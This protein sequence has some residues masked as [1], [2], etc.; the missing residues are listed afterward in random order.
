MRRW[1]SIAIISLVLMATP[2]WAQSYRLVWS[3]EFNGTVLDATK[4]EQQTGTGCPSLCGWGNNELEYYRPENTSVAGGLLTITAKAEVFGGANYTSS[5]IR[6]RLK[7]DW[8]YGRIEIRAKLPAGRGLWPAFWMLPTDNAY[9][10]WAASGEI[11]LM[12]YLGH[13]R[14]RVLGTIHYGGSFPN[15]TFSSTTY[16]GPAGTDFSTGFHDFAFE[17]EPCEM[18]WYIDGVLYAT[19]RDWNSTAAGYPAPFN[20]RFHLLIN[21]AVG[22]NL[23]G[24]PD[25]STVF[26]QKLQLDYVRVYQYQDV[27]ACVKTFDGMDHNAPLS[28]GWF[29]FNGTQGSGTIAGS[30]TDLPTAQGCRASLAATYTSGNL[31]VYQGGFG[32][33]NPMD[34]TGMTHFNLWIKPDPGQS[35]RLELNLQDDDNGDNAIPSVPDGRDDEFQYNLAV[36]PTGPGAVAGGGWQRI[37]IPLSAFTDDNSFHTGG[38][39]IFDPKPVSAGGNGQLINV[40]VAVVNTGGS[41]STFR[42]DLW[43]F[44]RQASSYAGRVWNDA[45]GNGV[46]DPAES[47]IAGVTVQLWDKVLNAQ[48]ATQVTPA[49]GAYSFPALAAGTYEVRVLTA[50]L[51]SGSIATKDPDGLATL[52]S[53]V[54]DV[55]CDA[56][57][58]SRDFGFAV[59]ALGVGDA[60]VGRVRL[61]QNVP[62]PFHP[63]TTIAFELPHADLVT[64]TV[65]DVAGRP[66]RELLR[67][68]LAA[69]AHSVQWDGRDEQGRRQAEGVYFYALVTPEGRT[70]KRMALL[71]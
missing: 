59:G 11:D 30:T 71:R 7:G 8:T 2:T 56:A 55:G 31:P 21:M 47:G 19:K 40:V 58:T 53:C 60:A 16:V 42:T 39:G 46:L 45:N 61:A 3:D 54:E 15:N 37:S 17:W 51:P 66:V 10:V 65:L 44:A 28:N 62:N 24:S 38:N 64:L 32:R 25:A 26:P 36:S 33:A 50:T 35:Y 22:G 48:L 27:S 12:E 57:L 67:G 5:R 29:T 49:T 69:G 70:M 23:P 4:W 43:Q 63:S 14:D 52:G 1:C 20:K 34:L 68:E 9:G 18:R 6:S 41:N 13:Q